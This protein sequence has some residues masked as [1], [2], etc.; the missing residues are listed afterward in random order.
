MTT[1][2]LTATPEELAK[3]FPITDRPFAVWYDSVGGNLKWAVNNDVGEARQE[4]ADMATALKTANK[5]R[6]KLILQLVNDLPEP[7]PFA[8]KEPVPIS[9][10]TRNLHDASDKL[11][12]VKALANFVQSISLN[13]HDGQ[14]L[15]L[16]PAQLSG[17]YYVLEN[18]I[19]RAK[20]A[21]DL[22][23]AARKQP[24][25]GVT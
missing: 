13:L 15:T 17:F 6:I 16:Q 5:N 8:T 14:A 12:E 1:N 3:Q 25:R 24:E 21:E 9:A 19:D 2:I 18:I 4:F 10:M 20:E 7:V 22:I 23:Y 11:V